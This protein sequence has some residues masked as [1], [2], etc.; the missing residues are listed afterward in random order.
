MAESKINYILALLLLAFLIY[1]TYNMFFNDLFPIVEVEEEPYKGIINVWDY[2]R[3]NVETGSRYS[4]MEEKIKIFEKKHPGV[5]V[6]FTPMDWDV[7]QNLGEEFNQE[8]TPDIMPINN[9]FSQINMLEPLD[10]YFED[11][12][13]KFIKTQALKGSKYEG[14]MVAYPVALT[15]YSMYLN[16]DL[17]NKR[18]ISPPSNGNWSY[19][20]FVEILQK[21]TYTNEEE[22]IIDY[23]GFNSFITPGYYNLWGII[24]S[25]GAEI[26]NEKTNSYTFYGEKALGGLEKVIDLKEKYKVV[27]DYFGLMK[28]QECWEMFYKDKKV[29][30]YPTGSW[31]VKV[32]EDLEE[33][34]EGF[35]FDVANYPI[36]NINMP[37][38]VGDGII[39]YGII[40][41]EDEKK[42][43]MCVKFLKSL[44]EDKNQRSLEEI[45]LFTVKK[46]IDDMYIN[47]P[48]MKKIEESLSYTYYLPLRDDWMDIDKILQEEIKKAILGEKFSYEAIEDGKERIQQLTK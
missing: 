9:G 42:R 27:P 29:A 30:V 20:E 21:L 7:S 23:F 6:K 8:D 36:G 38:V 2:P 12:E 40:E 16:L 46:G 17:F 25:D 41:Q 34:G 22:G 32:L 31:A 28:E 47:N 24:L 39:S 10:D 37:I 1:W 33:K 5:Y 14:K 18:G 35:N 11:E 48:K 3:L 4:W 13:L 43:E 26:F 15:T 19:E 45:G 44:T